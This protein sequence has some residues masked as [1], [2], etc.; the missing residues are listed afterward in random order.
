MHVIVVDFIL[1]PGCRERFLPLILE[2]A[3][4]SVADEPGCRRFD[5][6]EDPADPASIFL[7]EI[8]DD[9]AAFEAHKRTEHFRRF[10]AASADMVADKRVRALALIRA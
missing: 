7:Y 5:V 9:E 8:Y 2:N 3:R 1:R 4:R 6:C 10:E